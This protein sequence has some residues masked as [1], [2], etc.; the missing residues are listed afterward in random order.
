MKTFCDAQAF[1]EYGPASVMTEAPDGNINSGFVYEQLLPPG[2]LNW[3]F[4]RL[5]LNQLKMA[6]RAVGTHVLEA[7][8]LATD[9]MAIKWLNLLNLWVA[10]PNATSGYLRYS[11][12]GEYWYQGASFDFGADSPTAPIDYFRASPTQLSL[13][14]AS[15]NTAAVEILNTLDVT[16]G[17]M[18]AH[19][20][21]TL[22]AIGPA[23]VFTRNSELASQNQLIVTTGSLSMPVI[24]SPTYLDDFA[25]VTGLGSVLFR[26]RLTHYVDGGDND[27]WF[28]IGHGGAGFSLKRFSDTTMASGTELYDFATEEPDF[29]PTAIDINS[30]TGRIIVAGTESDTDDLLRIMYSDDFG[31]TWADAAVPTVDFGAAATQAT[32]ERIQYMGGSFWVGHFRTVATAATAQS[33]FFSVDNGVTWYRSQLLFAAS[34]EQQLA[35]ADFDFSGNYWLAARGSYG[36]FQFKGS[37]L[38]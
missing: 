30:N 16:T 15:D 36:A 5:T 38:P 14:A 21:D 12:D 19:P 29:V 35:F 18:S 1:F 20:G 8:Q 17:A 33:I 6:R 28:G 9:Y 11:P 2:I 4:N 10:I 22:S 37:V 23:R 24:V 27:L 34:D 31:N 26:H 7:S 3:F 32:Y 25:A 13:Y